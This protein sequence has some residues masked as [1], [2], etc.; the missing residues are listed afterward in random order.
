[1]L[2]ALSRGARGKRFSCQINGCRK[3][4]TVAGS[5]A[6]PPVY[7]T[8]YQ[9]GV[10]AVNFHE[11][12]GGSPETGRISASRVKCGLDANVQAMPPSASERLSVARISV[13][14]PAS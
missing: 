2:S 10:S 13:T 11:M 8:V 7:P 6:G 12:R 3:P 5:L 14:E 9:P 1:M 4:S